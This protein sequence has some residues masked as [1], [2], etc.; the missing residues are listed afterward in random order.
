MI[1]NKYKNCLNC[2]F[3]TR[4]RN[5]FI[6]FPPFYDKESFW[7][8]SQES[9]TR[10]EREM[11]KQNNNDFIGKGKIQFEKWIEEYNI[12][13]KA[14]CNALG[15][16]SDNI[17]TFNAINGN[18]Y[19]DYEQY[20]IENP[21]PEKD[22]ED[23]LSCLK[24]YWD[25]N[26]NKALIP[27]RNELNTRCCKHFYDFKNVGEKTLSLCETEQAE[28]RETKRFWATFLI[29]FATLIITAITLYFTIKK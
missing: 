27:K 18:K 19:S 26:S 20:G 29:S 16:K 9:L 12:K 22:D 3:C 1:R 14:Y 4:N 21:P 23:Y 25:E 2:A 10:E 13:Q 6:T 15:I 7:S 28:N 24:G 5:N 17:N 11:L 8:Y